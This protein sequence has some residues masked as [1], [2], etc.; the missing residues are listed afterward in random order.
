[1]SEFKVQEQ[2]QTWVI[3]EQ[4]KCFTFFIS[5]ILK[6]FN[7]DYEILLEAHESNVF[8]L[9]SFIQENPFTE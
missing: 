8:I 1:M 9:T 4:E 5:Y 7:C 3:R 6:Y 2:C